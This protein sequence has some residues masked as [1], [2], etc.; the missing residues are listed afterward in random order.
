[1]FR[2][3]WI[4]NLGLDWAVCIRRGP[5]SSCVAQENEKRVAACRRALWQNSY[6]YARR[7]SGGKQIKLLYRVSLFL[8]P[9]SYHEDFL[10]LRLQNSAGLCRKQVFTGPTHFIHFI[11]CDLFV[12]S[13]GKWGQTTVYFPRGIFNLSPVEKCCSCSLWVKFLAHGRFYQRKTYMTLFSSTLWSIILEMIHISTR[14]RLVQGSHSL[15]L[16][17]QN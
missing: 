12:L 1:M 10:L 17:A 11:S 16:F 7:W 2:Q 14:H 6:S 4:N 9:L 3:I 15:E 5:M 8:A 13:L